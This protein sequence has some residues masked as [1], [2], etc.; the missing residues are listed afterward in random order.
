MKTKIKF[1]LI[2][3]L[4]FNQLNAQENISINGYVRNYTGVLIEEPNNFSIIQNTFNLN[5]EKRADKIAF[6][7]NPFQ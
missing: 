2:L 1:V 3:M 7:I 6:K 5:F 4:I